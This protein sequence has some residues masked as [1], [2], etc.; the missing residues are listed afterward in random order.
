M[1]LL[2]EYLDARRDED[3]S[4]LRRVMALR[5]MVAT[6]VSQRQIADAL[7]I[8]QPAVSQQ[9]RHA[10]GLDPI[11]PETLLDAARPVLKELAA[12]HGYNRLAVFGSVARNEA[13]QDSDIDLIVEAP[14]GTSSFQFIRFKQLLEKV[15]GRDIDL[16][17]YGGLAPTLDDDIRRDAVL[18]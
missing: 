8:S 7:G 1:T 3:M 4:R 9:L 14:P 18:L 12:E 10:P 11:H 5:A 15:L 6:G 2:A 17:S 16:I 13:R